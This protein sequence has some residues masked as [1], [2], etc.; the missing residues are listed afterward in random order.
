MNVKEYGIECHRSTNHLYDEKPYEIH[1]QMVFDT[2]NKFIYLIPEEDRQD[3]LNACWV[4]DVIEDCRQ[5]Y[6]DVKAATNERVA[7]LAYALTNEKG[8]NRK[9]R[10]NAKYYRG[11]LA[12]PHASFVKICDRI[13]NYEYSLRQKS[14]MAT[15][16]E[17]EMAEFTDHLFSNEYN[18]MFE[19]IFQLRHSVGA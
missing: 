16:Y 1:L 13:A 12:V 19:Y 18:P 5:T 14:S 8:K 4:H 7:E 15:K 2:A 3:V 6:N 11:I 10:A 17:K 9:E